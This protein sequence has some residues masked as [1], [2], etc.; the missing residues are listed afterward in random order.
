[1]AVRTRPV[2]VWQRYAWV[3]GILFV[4]ALVAEVV[5]AIGVPVSQDDSAAKIAKAVYNHHKRLWIIAYLSVV[6][7]VMFPIYL[8]G[9]YNLLRMTAARFAVLGSL[10]LIGGVLFVTLHGVSDI[11]ITGLVGTK[12][13]KEF[14]PQHDQGVVYMLYLLTF[15]LESVGDIFGSLFAVATG[16]LVIESGALPRWLGWVS[17]VAGILLFLQG[18]TLGGVIADFGVLVDIAGFVLL[19]VFVLV[20]SIIMLSRGASGVPTPTDAPLDSSA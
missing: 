9:L 12:L 5:V 7:A 6:Y 8:N 18:F 11:A 19:L 1:M 2:G 13:A 20:S 15:A 4:I 17:I 14:G 10:V 16:L 3:A